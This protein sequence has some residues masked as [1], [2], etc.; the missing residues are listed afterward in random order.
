MVF[1][2]I[3]PLALRLLLCVL[4]YAFTLLLSAFEKSGFI[5]LENFGL[6]MLLIF[7]WITITLKTTYQIN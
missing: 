7:Y 4:K 2:T 3:V 6:S 5:S 1:T